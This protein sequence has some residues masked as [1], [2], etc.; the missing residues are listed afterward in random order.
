[1]HGYITNLYVRRECRGG[2]GTSLLTHALN[3]L[4]EKPV[5]AVILWPTPR[6]RTLYLRQAFREPQDILELRS[7]TTSPG[8]GRLGGAR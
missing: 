5:D 8:H 7:K 2:I 4:R 3:W 6:S 1:M